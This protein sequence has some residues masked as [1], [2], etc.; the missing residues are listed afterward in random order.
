[1]QHSASF[2]CPKQH[3]SRNKN[4]HVS[5]RALINTAYKQYY[6]LYFLQNSQTVFL[7]VM[8]ILRSQKFLI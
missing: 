4:E 5:R 7:I 1:M 6:T 2:Q 8:S 3:I